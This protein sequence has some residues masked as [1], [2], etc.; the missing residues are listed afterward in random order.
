MTVDELR[1]RRAR[2]GK[3]VIL[4][5]AEFTFEGKKI[6]GKKRDLTLIMTKSKIIIIPLSCNERDFICKR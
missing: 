5:C 4:K 2:A 6:E 1:D 3:K